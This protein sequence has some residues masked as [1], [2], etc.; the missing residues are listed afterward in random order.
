MSQINQ[1]ILNRLTEHKLKLA[2]LS[3]AITNVWNTYDPRDENDPVIYGCHFLLLDM[4]HEADLI[5]EELQERYE[6]KAQPKP[7]PKQESLKRRII[8]PGF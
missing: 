6:R 2:F 4:E 1:S 7:K 8:I 5:L 3:E